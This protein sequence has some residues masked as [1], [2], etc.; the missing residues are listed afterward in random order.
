MVPKFRDVLP[1]EFPGVPPPRE[2]EF[3][4]IMPQFVSQCEPNQTIKS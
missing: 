3:I 1:E 4:I 2:V